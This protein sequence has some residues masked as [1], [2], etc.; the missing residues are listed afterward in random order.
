[1]VNGEPNARAVQ[2]FLEVPNVVPLET[3]GDGLLPPDIDGNRR[4]RARRLAGPIVGTQDDGAGY[5]AAS[6]ALNIW[7]LAVQWNARIRPPRWCSSRS[8]R[9]PR[10][11]RSSRARRRAATVSR[12]PGITDPDQYLDILSYRQRPT[13][14]ARLPELREVRVARDQPVRR[15]SSG[16]RGRALVRDPAQRAART[17]STSRARTRRPMASIA[18][19]A[20]SRRTKKGDMALGYSVVNGT[21]VYPGYPLHRPSGR[22]CARTDDARRGHDRSTGPASRGRL[23]SRWG[24]YSS[25]NIDPTDDCTF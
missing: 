7:E 2:F 6:D 11:T 10:S 17:R 3:I 15:G 14:P 21:N 25:M 4:S 19:W 16:H 5:G 23:N 9:S 24:D 12:R 22:R 18:G 8:C 20:A 1:M 13:Y